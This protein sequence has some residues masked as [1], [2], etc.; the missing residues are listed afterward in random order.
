MICFGIENA[1]RSTVVK[2]DF[3][4][5]NRRCQKMFVFGKRP[6]QLEGV[7]FDPVMLKSVLN[8]S[9]GNIFAFSGNDPRFIVLSRAPTYLKLYFC[10]HQELL[11]S[12]ILLR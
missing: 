10:H 9:L 12:F 1:R 11:R 2:R 6:I 3:V 7:R 5:A 4:N 8:G